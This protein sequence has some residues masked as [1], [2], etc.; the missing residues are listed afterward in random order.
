MVEAPKSLTYACMVSRESVEIAMTW[1]SLNDLE[2]NC[3]CIHHTA[4]EEPNKI[5]KFSR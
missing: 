2:V 1:A 5:D 3:L 4:V